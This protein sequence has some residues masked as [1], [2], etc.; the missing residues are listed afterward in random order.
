MIVA[1]FSGFLDDGENWEQAFEQL[2]ELFRYSREDNSIVIW[3][4]PRMKNVTKPDGFL[5]RL[6]R[7][8]AQYFSILPQT[9]SDKREP[10]SYAESMVKA[11]HPLIE[12]E[13]RV[14]VA[15]VRFD[16]PIGREQL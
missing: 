14:N 7:W 9:E 8:F 4:E 12:G 1:N 16:L 2:E 13:F 3:I 6:L 5:A 11:K 10:K 15:V